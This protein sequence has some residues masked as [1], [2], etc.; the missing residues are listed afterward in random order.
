MVLGR[1]NIV[2][3]PMALL[4]L[5]RNATVVLCHSRT[6]DLAEEVRGADVLV[7]A[8]GRAELIK[9]SWI[10]EGAVVIDVGMNRLPDGKLVGDVEFGSAQLRAS[11]ITPVPGAWPNDGR[12][13]MANTLQAA[14]TAAGL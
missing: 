7:A 5:E 10:Q 1:S 6:R 11:W 8:I 9:G 2:G 13:A 12:D 4:L 3:K 14:R